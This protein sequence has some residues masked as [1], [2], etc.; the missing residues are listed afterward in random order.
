MG[1]A[2]AYQALKVLF[3]RWEP[4]ELAVVLLIL[5]MLSC[6]RQIVLEIRRR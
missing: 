2:A 4:L 6:T 3:D 5:V 1:A